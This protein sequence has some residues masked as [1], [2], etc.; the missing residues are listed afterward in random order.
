[1]HEGFKA[2]KTGR[3]CTIEKVASPPYGGLISKPRPMGADSLHFQKA[4]DFSCHIFG[5]LEVNGGN[6]A[7]A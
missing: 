4:L 5:K 1:M 6:S 3:R 7:L 2:A